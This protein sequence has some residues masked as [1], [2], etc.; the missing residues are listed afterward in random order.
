MTPTPVA[1]SAHPLKGAEPGH[2]GSSGPFVPGEG[3][4]H[5]ARR[6]LQGPQWTGGAGSTAA[7]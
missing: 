7:A 4:G 6:G 2:E 5:C 1:P 3:P